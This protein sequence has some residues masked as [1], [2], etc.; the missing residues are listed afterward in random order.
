MHTMKKVNKDAVMA[1]RGGFERDG[2]G[3]TLAGGVKEVLSQ[4][5]TVKQIGRESAWKCLGKSILA[6][7]DRKWTVSGGA[8]AW[9]CQ[10]TER[11]HRS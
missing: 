2:R 11:A 4:E 10:G 6:K 3:A 9:G 7:W 1:T 8:Q 5:M